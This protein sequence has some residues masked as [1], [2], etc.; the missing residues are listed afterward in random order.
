M[1]IVSTKFSKLSNEVIN[2]IK[3]GKGRS[4]LE[5]DVAR[6]GIQIKRKVIENGE[7]KLIEEGSFKEVSAFEEK[8][9]QEVEK[10]EI[11]KIGGREFLKK[12][13]IGGMGFQSIM[14]NLNILG[15]QGV[16]AGTLIVSMGSDD[17]KED[18]LIN[19]LYNANGKGEDIGYKPA[20]VDEVGVGGQLSNISFIIDETNLKNGK[21]IYLELG[22]RIIEQLGKSK[23]GEEKATLGQLTYTF[24][25]KEQTFQSTIASDNPNLKGQLDRILE[26]SS[27]GNRLFKSDE[28]KLKDMLITAIQ[29]VKLEL[30]QRRENDTLN[31]ENLS[32]I[33]KNTITSIESDLKEDFNAS[34]SNLKSLR[35]RLELEVTKSVKELNKEINSILEKNG[36]GV[37]STLN[38]LNIKILKDVPI[39]EDIVEK[40]ISKLN[41]SVKEGTTKEILDE[42]KKQALEEV[43]KNGTGEVS[44]KKIETL[45]KPYLQ[46]HLQNTGGFQD[47]LTN[48]KNPKAEI[49]FKETLMTSLDTS[50]DEM[51]Q[52]K[53]NKK[54]AVE[55]KQNNSLLDIIKNFFVSILES[56]STIFKD[57]ELNA[58]NTLTNAIKNTLD[59]I[60][61]MQT[62]DKTNVEKL[63][64][65][66]N[67][68]NVERSR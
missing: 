48:G 45:I 32:N 8:I 17:F 7:E 33:V 16:F 21:K 31:S 23:V 46:P 18:I 67:K 5:K 54:G 51:L 1:E 3:S 35:N 50:I 55:E 26:F 43:K 12:G 60:K 9:R 20:S 49:I 28:E 36:L 11:L 4:D 68:E 52:G 2:K 27:V 53:S 63:A 59:D 38:D 15:H 62:Q 10:G 19:H 39:T 40:C 57:K 41:S 37:N 34:D 66:R 25:L 13:E 44:L 22:S 58:A 30:V 24:D 64:Q 6:A 65:S 14:N 47:I 42:L 61:I 29:Y 56:V